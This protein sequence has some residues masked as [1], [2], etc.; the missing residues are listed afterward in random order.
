MA[1]IV[2]GVQYPKQPQLALENDANGAPFDMLTR[3]L[4]SISIRS[5]N[6]VGTN[7]SRD[8]SQV[9]IIR[10]KNNKFLLF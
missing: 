5:N 1:S 2:N 10:K 8:D 6:N 9:I 4:E 3:Y 7:R